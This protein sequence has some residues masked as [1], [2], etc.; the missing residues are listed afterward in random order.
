MVFVAYLL[1]G[2]RLCSYEMVPIDGD[3]FAQQSN[4]LLSERRRLA[5]ILLVLALIFALC[6]LPYN[7]LALLMDLSILPEEQN[8]AAFRLYPFALLLGTVRCMVVWRNTK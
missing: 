7:I 4:K 8:G 6:W 1:M 3:T 2:M 5:K